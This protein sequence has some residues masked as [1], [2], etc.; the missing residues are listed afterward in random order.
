[1]VP[2]L[3][4]D[5]LDDAPLPSVL[6]PL[7]QQAHARMS[8]MV[9]VRGEAAAFAPTLVALMRDVDPN[10]P[11]F[12]VMP[13]DRVLADSVAGQR[14]LAWI[15]SLFG[16]AGLLLAA[17]GLYGVL[18]HW[19]EERT[20][21]IGVRRAIGAT[22]ERIVGQI[23][24]NAA[25]LVGIGLLVGGGL[26]VPWADLMLGQLNYSDGGAWG[27]IVLVML[28]IIAAAS[29][30]VAVPSRRALRVAPSEALRSD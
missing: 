12:W 29:V 27:V 7:A 4:L 3:R 14:I 2:S 13:F 1:V 30:A 8:L 26:S 15:Y 20:R 24:R 10:T 9:H 23:S 17:A 18:A 5:E 22:S 21:E 19:V 6:I 25:W 11:V 16:T 28:T